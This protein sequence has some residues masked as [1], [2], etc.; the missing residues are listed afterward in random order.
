MVNQTID[1]HGLELQLQER[2]ARYQQKYKLSNAD[3][4]WVF[5][6]IGTHYYFRDICTR[7]LFDSEPNGPGG[8][9]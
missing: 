7:G 4:A 8:R 1:I 5:L 2:V 9:F 6:R 3:L